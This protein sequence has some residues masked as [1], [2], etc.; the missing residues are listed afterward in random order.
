[1]Q[2]TCRVRSQYTQNVNEDMGPV[3]LD[4]GYNIQTFPRETHLSPGDS[5][6][7]LYVPYSNCT[8]SSI[9]LKIRVNT[10]R[11]CMYQTILDSNQNQNKEQASL[12]LGEQLITSVRTIFP[13]YVLSIGINLNRNEPFRHVVLSP[14]LRSHPS[15]S[16][17]STPESPL[18]SEFEAPPPRSS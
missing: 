3:S 1:M 8:Y 12:S 17:F 7:P 6:L 2:S 13:L 5:S 11:T 10:Y 15:Y 4:G 18:L 14:S 9:R 16:A